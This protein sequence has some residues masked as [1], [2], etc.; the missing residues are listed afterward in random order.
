MVENMKD[1]LF[2]VNFKDKANIGLHKTHIT[3]DNSKMVY[4]KEKVF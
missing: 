1:S 4:L 3:K 2:L